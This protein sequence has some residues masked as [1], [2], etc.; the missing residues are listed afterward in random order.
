MYIEGPPPLYISEQTR[1]DRYQ[2]TLEAAGDKGQRI[3]KATNLMKVI[4]A[5]KEVFR[6]NLLS[7]KFRYHSTGGI[8]WDKPNAP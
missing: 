4:N 5:W 3:K 1:Q 8:H 7:M 6:R 2:E